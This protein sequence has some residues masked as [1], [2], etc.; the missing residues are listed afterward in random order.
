MIPPITSIFR[1]GVKLMLVTWALGSF[2]CG[3]AGC[4]RNAS[5]SMKGQANTTITF[6]GLA[7]DQDGRP[8]SGASFQFRVEAYPKDWSFETRGRE[9][10]VSMLSAVSDADGRF[11]FTVTGCKLIRRKAELTGYRELSDKGASAASTDNWFY[12]LIAWSDITYKTDPQNPAVYVLVK[13]G[14]NVVSVL[15]C[16][17]GLNRSENGWELNQPA[18]PT[19]PS[20]SGVTCK[21]NVPTTSKFER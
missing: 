7:V 12:S 3:V 11:Q 18:W 4:D 16:R 2:G 13:N 5:N 21:P 15:P 8:L 6:Y 1:Q 19:R 14:S 17:G 10:D 9:N 20:L